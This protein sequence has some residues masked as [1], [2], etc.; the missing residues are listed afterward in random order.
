MTK[1]CLIFKIISRRWILSQGNRGYKNQSVRKMT[2]IMTL[3]I[4][5]IHKYVHLLKTL[6]SF[7]IFIF[8]P[9]TLRSARSDAFLRSIGAQALHGGPAK[10]FHLSSYHRWYRLNRFLT[11]VMNVKP[12]IYKITQTLI[13]RWTDHIN[14]QVEATVSGIKPFLH[15]AGHEYRSRYKRIISSV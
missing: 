6:F 4:F 14:L 1:F 2:K 13:E 3:V 11:S 15:M 8:H 9:S 7:L 5:E 10:N 12:L